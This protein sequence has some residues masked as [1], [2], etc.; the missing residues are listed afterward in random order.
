MSQNELYKPCPGIREAEWG[1]GKGGVS[2]AGPVLHARVA[3]STSAT[4]CMAA[5][6]LEPS[7]PLEDLPVVYPNQYIQGEFWELKF[8]IAKLTH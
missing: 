6:S 1:L 8:I 5:A 3:V 2:V 7:R 4:T